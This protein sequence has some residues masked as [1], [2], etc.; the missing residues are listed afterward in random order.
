MTAHVG[1]FPVALECCVHA[2]FF[3]VVVPTVGSSYGCTYQEN[4]NFAMAKN[5]EILNNNNNDVL[6]PFCFLFTVSLQEEDVRPE[7]ESEILD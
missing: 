2:G 7:S 4:M 1:G 6:K 5:T 3:L